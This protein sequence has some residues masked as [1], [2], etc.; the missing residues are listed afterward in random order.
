MLH[1]QERHAPLTRV[2]VR[3]PDDLCASPGFAST[4]VYFERLAQKETRDEDR[5]CRLLEVARFY[6]SLAQLI[7]GIPDGYKQN[8]NAKLALTRA[9]RWHGR[10]EECAL[11]RPALPQ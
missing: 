4:A 10:A 2:R 3:V 8:D 5:R 9:Q 1:T 6:R 7:P 11:F